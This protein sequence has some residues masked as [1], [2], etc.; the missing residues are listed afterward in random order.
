MKY[1]FGDFGIWIAR[2]L[3]NI[4]N[5]NEDTFTKR[6]LMVAFSRLLV[7]YLVILSAASMLA[8]GCEKTEPPKVQL[9]ASGDTTK[10]ETKRP[11]ETTLARADL[12]PAPTETAA[13]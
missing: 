10:V 7:N 8:L 13:N 11:A 1:V 12:K 6:G 9:K 3:P 5:G 2:N 4:T